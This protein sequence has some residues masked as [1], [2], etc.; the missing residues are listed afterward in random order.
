MD[1][2]PLQKPS[3]GGARKHFEREIGLEVS[4]SSHVFRSRIRPEN[5]AEYY[6]LADE[7]AQL[8][9]S[10]PGYLSWKSY[11]ADDGERVSIHEWES[12]EHLKAWREHPDHV[13]AQEKGR[14]DFYDEYTLYVCD[15]PR[16]SRHP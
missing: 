7:M 13:K 12:A 3:H 15:N 8:A 11:F 1:G 5:A 10:M 9:Q 14:M 4:W 6:A 16:T 2:T